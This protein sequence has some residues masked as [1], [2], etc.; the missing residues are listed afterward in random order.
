MTDCAQIVSVN[1]FFLCVTGVTHS[2]HPPIST[3]DEIHII[4][5][6]SE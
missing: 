1:V 2:T 6:A 4:L 3:N 5:T